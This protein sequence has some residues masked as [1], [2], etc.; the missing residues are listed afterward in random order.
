MTKE[1]ITLQDAIEAMKPDYLAYI[2]RIITYAE[3]N[4]RVSQLAR[5]YDMIAGD[6][7]VAIEDDYE[8]YMDEKALCAFESEFC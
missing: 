2:D 8:L 7:C 4:R 3:F 6:L 1:T 5:K